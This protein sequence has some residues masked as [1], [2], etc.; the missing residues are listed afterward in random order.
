MSR[1][2]LIGT[3]VK[4][5]KGTEGRIAEVLEGGYLLESGNRV[6]AESIAQVLEPPPAPKKP[7][8]L[9]V[10]DTCYY[11]GTQWWEQYG[12]LELK[13]A[14]LREGY[15]SCAKPDGYYT[16][17]ILP[18]ELSR[19]PVAKPTKKSPERIPREGRWM[20]E[21][22]LQKAVDRAPDSCQHLG[23]YLEAAEEMEGDR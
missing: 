12:G 2:I 22:D 20:I 1:Q 3:K 23:E 18:S 11:C 8:P 16:T 19:S 17:N 13:T 14:L 5:I 4:T 15:W 7:Q 9:A 21:S 6:R 10:G